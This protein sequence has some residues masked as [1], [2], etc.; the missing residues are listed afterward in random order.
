MVNLEELSAKELYE[1][2]RKK[3][4]EEARLAQM[5]EQLRALKLERETLIKKH[6]EALAETDRQ[7]Q[8]LTRQ[9]EKMLKEHE[10]ALS[11]LDARLKKL[12][13]E[14]TAKKAAV[15]EASAAKPA[16]PSRPSLVQEEL[17]PPSDEEETPAQKA[18]TP[19]AHKP[20]EKAKS[21]AEELEIL[22]EHLRKIMKGRSYI[23]DS[24]LREKLQAANY[25]PANLG[26]LLETLVRQAR[27]V[28]RSG[29]NYVL[30]RQTKKK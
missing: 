4:Q 30:G 23:S 13:A 22:M 11:A 14:T 27:L 9:R 10:S 2:A 1:L 21:D 24:L 16:T 5:Q 3:E 12:G 19:P 8:E 15:N 18:D 25:K 29:G 6:E 17:P 26:K 28:R 20:R 7:L